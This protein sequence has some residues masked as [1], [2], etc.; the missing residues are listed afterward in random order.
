MAQALVLAALLLAC[1]DVAVVVAQETERIQGTRPRP[2]LLRRPLPLFDPI[3]ELCVACGRVLIWG[4]RPCS[5]AA[6]LLAGA[7]LMSRD[8]SCDALGRRAGT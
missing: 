8:E 7:D 4:T 6:F 3:S 5:V 1:S 2:C